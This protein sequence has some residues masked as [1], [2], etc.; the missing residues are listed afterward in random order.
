MNRVLI[1]GAN[2]GMGLA[3]TKLFLKKGW[4]VAMVDI[5]EELGKKECDKLKTEYGNVIEFFKCNISD[6]SDIKSM[7][8]SI[9]MK[10]DGGVDG[11]VNCA[12]IFATGACHNL[13]EDQWDKIMDVDVKA[14]YL[15]AKVFIPYMMS[16]KKG[17]IVN[18][19]SCAGIQGDY[20]MVAYCAAKG[21]VVNMTRAMALDYGKYNI[22][23]NTVSPAACATPMFKK[24]PQ[25]VQETFAEANPLKH[26]CTPEEVAHAIYFLISEESNSCN[27]TNLEVTGGINIACGSPVV[28]EG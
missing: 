6:I 19:A 20:N 7:R 5:N 15:I 17:S 28:Q 13:E 1:T 21:A 14:I 26:L 2:Q 24:N 23:T 27:G 8:E 25:E 10:F 9:A 4:R 3:T 12:G 11:I 18:V 22:R 16:Q